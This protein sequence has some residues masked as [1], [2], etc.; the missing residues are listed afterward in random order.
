MDKIQLT[1]RRHNK[2]ELVEL[3]S[4]LTAPKSITLLESNF[5]R[6]LIVSC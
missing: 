3:D 4:W 1:V 5:H 6:N 2:E